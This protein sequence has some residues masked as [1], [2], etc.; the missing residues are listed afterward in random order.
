MLSYCQNI[1]ANE[2]NVTT[3]EMYKAVA[4]LPKNKAPGYDGLMFEHYQFA[5]PRLNVIL[6]IVLQSFLKHGFLPDGFMITM[7]VPIFFKNGDMTAKNNYQPIAMATVMSNILEICVQMKLEDYLWT[8]DNQFAHKTGH[9]V[10]L[11]WRKSFVIIINTELRCM[12]AFWMPVKHLVM[13]IIGHG[14]RWW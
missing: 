13:W 7:V 10:F 4:E 3:T 1:N 14:L 12:S 6:A 11:F 5:S 9:S 8:T 2:I